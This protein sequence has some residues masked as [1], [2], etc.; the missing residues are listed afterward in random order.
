MKN[1]VSR[2]VTQQ[3]FQHMFDRNQTR[4]DRQHNEATEQENMGQ[5]RSAVSRDAALQEHKFPE[6]AQ[7]SA[8]TETFCVRLPDSPPPRP[9]RDAP[10]QDSR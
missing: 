9:A 2:L 1:R 10:R 8:P 6:V 3:F 4:A 5:A 7:A